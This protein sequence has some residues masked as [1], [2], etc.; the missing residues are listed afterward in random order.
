MMDIVINAPTH[1]LSTGDIVTITGVQG[2]ANANVVNHQITVQNV[3]SFTLNNQSGSGTYSG[4]GVWTSNSRWQDKYH[5][6]LMRSSGLLVENVNFFYIPGT[7]LE[8]RKGGAGG[9]TGPKLTFDAEKA[10]IWDCKVNRAYRGF[11]IADVD[12]VIGRLEG[13]D[14]RDY[15]LRIP[16]GPYGAYK[17]MAR[18]TSNAWEYGASASLPSGLNTVRAHVGA[19]R[20]TLIIAELACSLIPVKTSLQTSTHGIVLTAT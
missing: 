6:L 9:H 1:G 3:N 17:L 18:F 11:L 20:F 19:A 7:A 5:G 4:G 14:L 10:F 8:I 16:A 13:S 12:A 2:I 15:G